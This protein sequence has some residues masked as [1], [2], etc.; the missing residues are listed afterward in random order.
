MTL[1]PEVHRLGGKQL[2]GPWE[3][4]VRWKEGRLQTAQD[5]GE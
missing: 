5:K 2:A 3:A 1:G 4:A